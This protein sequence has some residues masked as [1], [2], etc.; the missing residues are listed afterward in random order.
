[1]CWPTSS[2]TRR[3]S[4]PLACSC[5]RW[6]TGSRAAQ[7][8][9]HAPALYPAPPGDHPPPLGARSGRARE[10]AHIVEGLL[11]ALDI[12]DE[13]IA[14]IRRSQTVDTARKNLM[15]TSS[16]AKCRRRP[17]WTCNCAGW[18]RW[19][20]RS[21]RKSSTNCASASPI[22]ED[23]LQHPEKIL[24]VIRKE[25]AGDQGGVRR[26]PPHPDRRPHQRHADHHRPAPRPEGLG[27]PEQ[28]RRGA[29]PGLCR[30]QA[31]A[32]AACA[33]SGQSSQ[34]DPPSSPTRATSSTSS[35]QTGAA[36]AGRHPRDSRG[37]QRSRLRFDR[38]TGPRCDHRGLTLPRALLNGE[39]GGL[40]FP[41][42]D[43][44]MVKRISLATCRPTPAASSR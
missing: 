7:P 38:L 4:R 37:R 5:W 2:N 31:G 14:T 28:E 25:T 12:L 23:L 20:A 30:D 21:C 33:R 17:F 34:A 36:A 32:F 27:Q 16:S 24:G 43:Q 19:S 41:G 6:W 11:R 18:L 44:G 22:C 1:M 9:A 3:C 29:P 13:V 8:Q 39:D 15:P 35:A 26:R 40:S 42:H 10:R